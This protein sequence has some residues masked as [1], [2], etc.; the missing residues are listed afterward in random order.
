MCA[1]IPDKESYKIMS[2]VHC[3]DYKQMT[4]E[5]RQWLFNTVIEMFDVDSVEFDFAEV[6]KMN[7]VKR[8]VKLLV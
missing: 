1:I 2:S 6:D 7:P 3:A 8:I 4:P 5:F